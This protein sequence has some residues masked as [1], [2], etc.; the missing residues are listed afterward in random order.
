MNNRNTRGVFD[1]IEIDNETYRF[2]FL[3]EDL[4]SVSIGQDYLL[5]I[6]KDSKTRTSLRFT[7]FV[8]WQLELISRVTKKKTGKSITFNE[9][10]S[11]ALN[12]TYFL[13]KESTLP[14]NNNIKRYLDRAFKIYSKT[15]NIDKY[16]FRSLVDL[17]YSEDYIYRTLAVAL[18]DKSLVT[19][20]EKR[21]LKCIFTNPRFCNQPFR[22]KSVGESE[23][24]YQREILK[25]VPETDIDFYAI[26]RFFGWQVTELFI[27][28]GVN[29]LEDDIDCNDLGFFKYLYEARCGW[30][31][32]EFEYQE[33]LLK[34][35]GISEE[36]FKDS[37]VLE[38]HVTHL[39]DKDQRAIN[40]I[41]ELR[42]KAQ[43]L[44]DRAIAD[45]EYRLGDIKA[46]Y[47]NLIQMSDIQGIIED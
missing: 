13:N 22:Q 20:S 18:F 4:P 21:L 11:E 36:E 25:Y 16:E 6:S 46:K 10:I 43:T 24:R 30:D 1:T 8:L 3:R 23:D 17:T 14:C 40:V 37:K 39:K 12:G 45:Y 35:Y 7:K 41:N 47:V 28:K 9:I 42:E 2:N 31:G 38:S 26:Y 5:T 29:A 27:Q 34:K 32:T 19:D 33:F 44:S 15:D